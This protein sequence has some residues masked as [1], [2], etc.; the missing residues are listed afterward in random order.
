MVTYKMADMWHT[1]ALVFVASY[2]KAHSFPKEL[3]ELGIKCLNLNLL[4]W[5]AVEQNDKYVIYVL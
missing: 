4:C 5:S 3:L 2:D 1:G